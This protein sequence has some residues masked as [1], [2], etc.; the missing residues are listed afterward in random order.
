MSFASAVAQ[1]LITDFSPTA[2]SAN[3]TIT[4][5][6]SGFT[7]PGLTIR[8][9]QGKVATSG[10]I[11]SD[12][13]ITV[14]VPS[15]IS[16]G[17]ISIQSSGGPENFTAQ[18]FTAVGSGPYIMDV[19]PAFGRPNDVI[20]ISGVHFSGVAKTGVKFNGVSAADAAAN[21]D[22]SLINV[23]VP[24]GATSGSITV[25]TALGTS[26]S[27]TPFTVIGPGPFITGFSPQ[28]GTS[29]TTVFIDGVH[30][31]GATNATF[32]GKA[33]LNFAAQSDTLI[34]VDAPSG[35]TSGPL[36]VNSP[37]GTF[38][39]SSN[40]FVPPVISSFAP[41]FGRAGTNVVISGTNFLGATNVT[42]NLKPAASFSV[43]NNNTI[44]ATVPAGAT[45]GT[46]RVTAPA[47]S[48]FSGSNFVLLPTIFGFSPTS[49]P[50]G[51]SVVITGANL[52]V[53]TTA[54]KFN[55]VAAAAPTGVS[56]GQLTAVVPSGTVTGP[57]SVTT[58]EG[59]YTNAN[60]FYLP[61]SITTFTPTNGPIGTRVTVTGQ[62]FTGAT[63]VTFNGTAASSFTVSNNS[64]LGATLPAGVTTG[65]VSVTTPAGTVSSARLF[66]V[67]PIITGF[68][69]T[70][71]LP[72]TNVTITGSSFLGATSVR[73]TGASATSF[74][75]VNNNQ[76]TATVP[77]SAVAG[78]ITVIAP[79]GTNTSSASFI[80][81]Y[82]ADLAVSVFST[83]NP[84]TVGSN[85]VYTIKVANHGPLAAP[86]VR[87]TNTLPDTVVLRSVTAPA[88]WFVSTNGNP[89][90]AGI[91]TLTTN[92]S[93]TLLV[94]VTPQEAGNMTN[95]VS[96]GSDYGDTA[97]TNNAT[98]TITTVLPLALLSIGGVSDQIQVAWPVLLTNYVLE[99]KS[100]L[101]TN[102]NWSAVS[103]IPTIS[104]SMNFVTIT[105]PG[106]AGFFRLRK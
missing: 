38:T 63:A 51:T 46:V 93:V 74:T 39:T 96:L 28:I 62:N 101:A 33:G 14:V 77:A 23:H 24:V 42:F 17:P 15:G 94:T 21:A 106:P 61:A 26:Q 97:S 91:G 80:L 75:V 66:Y 72:G 2:G 76:I 86:N 9:W 27:P 8:F 5:F 79:A 84:V 1:P 37:L 19:S 29:P 54:V 56:F 11:N 71:G 50:A 81:D 6:G 45:T 49:G 40:F 43:V 34:R 67:A 104:G 65:P 89:I 41:G 68:N 22:G 99:T 103:T 57:I 64:T 18:D 20:V 48:A 82:F 105:N 36:T 16:T 3:D 25:T 69:P 95:L 88:G 73:F 10:F 7:T 90:E 85:L 59:G 60:F 100:V 102:L 87:L 92:T 78:P 52:N 53:G 13:Q 55:G 4:L 44:S 30:F 32:N 31:T 83:P 12:S 35:V 70:H 47:G 98:A 58:G